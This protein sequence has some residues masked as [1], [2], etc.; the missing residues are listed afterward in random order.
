M[1]RFV[2]VWLGQLSF[3]LTA[4]PPH[5]YFAAVLFFHSLLV[6]AFRPDDE[7]SIVEVVIR[8]INLPLDFGRVVQSID[9]IGV[10][11]RTVLE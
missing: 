1:L 7:S 6:A 3:L 2:V 4:L 8:H 9:Q 10:H 5:Q 11:P